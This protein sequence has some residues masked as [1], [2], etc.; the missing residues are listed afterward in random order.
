MSAMSKMYSLP[1]FS[2]LPPCVTF[3]YSIFFYVKLIYHEIIYLFNL[4]VLLEY[5]LHKGKEFTYC[6]FS[7]S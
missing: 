5:T 4:T 2:A 3:L 1:A 6:E 7:V